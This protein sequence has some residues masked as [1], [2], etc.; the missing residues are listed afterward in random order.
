MMLNDTLNNKLE[1]FISRFEHNENQIKKQVHYNSVKNITLELL[2]VKNKKQVKKH[3]ESV[4]KFFDEIENMNFPI[5]KLLSEKLYHKYIF[6]AGRYLMHKSDFK[7]NGS[8]LF[9]VLLGV[10][11]DF[12][13]FYFDLLLLGLFIPMFTVLF[14]IYAYKVKS[15]AVNENRFF[16]KNWWCWFD[17]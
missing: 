14:F 8:L 16:M 11:I 6:E 15:R 7:T 9:I 13:V 2:M 4:L 3:M 12:I 10:I 1:S 17:K 5:E